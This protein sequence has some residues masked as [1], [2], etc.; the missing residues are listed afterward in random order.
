MERMQENLLN[1]IKSAGGQA[2]SQMESK[3]PV[4][5]DRGQ[6]MPA[7]FSDGSNI[8]SEIDRMQKE[9]V[10]LKE[11]IESIQAENTLMRTEITKLKREMHNVQADIESRNSEIQDSQDAIR[12]KKQALVALNT[13]A[14]SY[15][16]L[17]CCRCL[18][19][20]RRVEG[21]TVDNDALLELS[22]HVS[23]A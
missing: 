4:G 7:T 15:P 22:S 5:Q 13:P 14:P 3:T 17:C 1:A 9:I 10:S 20:R 2:S 21:S 18:K 11:E 12:T 8:D 19:S 16:W 23:M 6:R